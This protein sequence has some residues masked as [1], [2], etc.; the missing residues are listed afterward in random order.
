MINKL[1]NYYK[2]ESL[3]N[4]RLLVT[5]LPFL[6]PVL[7][8]IADV[9]F[10]SSTGYVVESAINQWSFLWLNVFLALEAGLIDQHEK[11][12]TQYKIITSS[13][14]NLKLYSVSGLLYE[15]MLS[16][17]VNLIFVLLTLILGGV[18][19]I[20]VSLINCLISVIGIF[21]SSLWLIPLY[22]ILA[23]I[24]NIYLVLIVS[25]TSFFLSPST[26]SVFGKLFPYN[27]SAIF[28]V[29]WIKLQVNGL[30]IKQYATIHPV[31][32]P[33]FASILLAVILT[34]L[35]STIFSR[36]EVKNNG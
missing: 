33:I 24:F 3:K 7:I 34:I 30:P 32:W 27:W 36:L 6:F 15:M 13:P 12:S 2:S 10:F 1:I 29:Y 35:A 17:K 22:T 26:Q 16:V 14:I 25:F 9:I 19:G 31:Y 5:K 11:N 8:I 28:P 4:K 20:K 18:M 23:R 21:L